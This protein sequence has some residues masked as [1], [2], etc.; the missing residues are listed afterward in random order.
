MTEPTKLPRAR[1]FAALSMERHREISAMGGRAVRAENRSFSRDPDFA[2][3]A[4]RKGGL[5]TPGEKRAFARDRE[6]AVEAGKRGGK[7]KAEKGPLS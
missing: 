6:L 7:A 2:A 1:G 3:E 5:A 4:G